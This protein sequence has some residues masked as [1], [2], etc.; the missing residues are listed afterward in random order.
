M[1]FGSVDHMRGKMGMCEVM[2]EAVDTVGSL[3]RLRSMAALHRGTDRKVR[4]HPR[5]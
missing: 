1:A 2:V 4:R 5:R 3:E